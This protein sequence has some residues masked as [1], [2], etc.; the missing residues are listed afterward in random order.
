MCCTLM[1]NLDTAVSIFQYHADIIT[2]PVPLLL[3]VVSN[4]RR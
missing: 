3:S 4:Y 1:Y 2:A